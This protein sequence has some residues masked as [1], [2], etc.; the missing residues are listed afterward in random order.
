M[1]WHKSRQFW[2]STYWP[3]VPSFWA[4]ISGFSKAMN[5]TLILIF[6]YMCM[7]ILVNIAKFK[8]SEITAQNFH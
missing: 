5:V 1:A 8:H 4:G 7:E 2:C 3:V 6:R